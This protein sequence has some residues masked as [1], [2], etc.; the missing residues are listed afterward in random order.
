MSAP[1]VEFYADFQGLAA[2]R[3]RARAQDPETLKAAA[4]QF[5]SLFTQMLL[6]SMREAGKGFG[7]SLFGSEQGD[8]YQS[9]FDEQ[10]ALQLSQ[11]G[12]LGLADMLI[13]QLSAGAPQGGGSI[14][15]APLEHLGADAAMRGA[16]R[17][18]AAG[19]Q[20]ADAATAA[21]RGSNSTGPGEWSGG[22]EDFIRSLWP[23]A[24]QAARELGVDP[25]A[26][27]AQA[28]LETGWGR[29]VPCSSGGECSFNLFGI[30]AGSQWRGAQVAVPTL[31]YEDG[32]AVRK[33]ERFR[34]YASPAESFRDY[35]RLIRGN[36][37]YREAL[38]AGGDVAAFANA[39]QRGGYA[40][41]PEYE[42]KIVAVAA[43]V[44]TSVSALKSGGDAPINV[45]GQVR[46]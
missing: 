42:R 43:D 34:A 11:G 38:N 5:E 3:T 20:R 41:D 17:A 8:F 7:D 25:H 29:S 9:M 27:L 39:L 13:R 24:R 21:E 26:L 4:Q 10:I 18:E 31:E 45:Y 15:G 2:L 33:I 19:L 37:R 40:T 12:G 1:P 32:V 6:K 30:K 44:R 16:V 46:T 23:H 22:K 35:A 14:G 36:P 28:A